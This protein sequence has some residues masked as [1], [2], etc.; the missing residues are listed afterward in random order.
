MAK[1]K[2]VRRNT[3]SFSPFWC[4]VSRIKG[5][6]IPFLAV[7]PTKTRTS[8]RDVPLSL[9]LSPSSLSLSLYLY[10]LVYYVLTSIT[11]PYKRGSFTRV[12][13]ATKQLIPH[14]SFFL[15]SSIILSYMGRRIARV[16]LRVRS[17]SF[18]DSLL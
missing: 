8:S 15:A 13:D 17:H 1:H 2:V 16:F 12:F 4:S 18:L 3:L 7:A 5:G 9:S 10:I 14:A 11:Q 6:K